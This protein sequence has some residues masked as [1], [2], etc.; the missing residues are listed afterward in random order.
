MSMKKRR[1]CFIAA[2]KDTGEGVSAA[3]A[4][5]LERLDIREAAASLEG[6][7]ASVDKLEKLRAIYAVSKL[8][9]TEATAFVMKALK[10]PVEDVRSTAC[11]VLG[12]IG[13]SSVT[14]ALVEALGDES[15]M[16]QRE[17]LTALS[18]FRDPG[19]LLHV[20]Q[21]LKSQDPGVV[22]R[23]IEIV[24]DSGDKRVEEAMLYY[25]ANGTPGM[26]SRALKALGTMEKYE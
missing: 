10:D 7:L 22:E 8:R 26:K 1:E 23:A 11:R 24:G 6:M 9:G 12:D 5:A 4:E 21:M 13:D 16:V 18:T 14:G 3:A 19:A 15:V 17:A 25:V 2:L 20:M